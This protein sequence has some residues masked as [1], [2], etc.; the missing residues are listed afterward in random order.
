MPAAAPPKIIPSPR[1]QPSAP[2]ARPVE[3]KRRNPLPLIGLV[4]TLAIG[5]WFAYRY[6]AAPEGAA[7]GAAGSRPAVAGAVRTARAE[8]G[9]IDQT[10][11]IGGRTAATDF[12]NVAAPRLQGPESRR[13]LV[14]TELAGPGSLVKKGDL[15]ASIDATA[16]IDHADDVHSTVVQAV[17][18]IRKRG[19]EHSVEWGNLLQ[20]LQV[21][22][23]EADKATL[24]ASA[25]EVRTE[26]DREMLKLYAE[27]TAAQHKQLM[28]EQIFRKNVHAADLRILE[29]TK[30]RHERHRDRHRNDVQRF[31]IRAL[32]DGLVVMQQIW[33]GGQMM[34]VQQGDQV[35]PN[36]TFM[37]IVD[38]RKMQVEA[39]LNQ[40]ESQ[41]VRI[42]QKATIG[43]D[44][45]PDL[46][47][48]GKVYN[49]GALATRGTQENFYV[50]SIPVLVE[51]EGSHE[52]LIPDLS[53][54]ADVHIKTTEDAL[55][56]PVE[57]I[58]Q[59][60]S[61][62]F[63]YV[64]TANGFERRD[65]KTGDRNYTH[66]QILSGLNTG[67]EVALEPPPVGRRK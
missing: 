5:G 31:T 7:P 21:S 51:I 63:V 16:L 52:R 48:P 11:R 27:E 37:K 28:V 3:P 57:A 30:I 41:M 62:P 66:T 18:D 47:F 44:A 22:Q 13:A 54:Y 29:I 65:V 46:K 19:A 2:A 67:D 36:Q 1:P 32:S 25:A 43:L 38:T 20:T 15:V 34:Q 23:A 56:V 17:A 59:A 55:R 53:A 61:G 50:R 12:T 33:R 9:V 6:L 40:A 45:F 24:D 39:N 10:L 60:D 26:I 64:R 14:I 4:A 49:L 8:V 58:Q 42:G 35:F